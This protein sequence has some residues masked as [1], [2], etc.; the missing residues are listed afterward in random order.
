MN[1]KY[2]QSNEGG[3][4]LKTSIVSYAVNYE[5]LVLWHILKNV[6]SEGCMLI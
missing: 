6:V 3:R 4:E 1:W 2:L 5:D